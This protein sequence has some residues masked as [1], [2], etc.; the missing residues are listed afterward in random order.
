METRKVQ[1]T[2]DGTYFVTL[3]KATQR[4]VDRGSLLAFENGKDGKLTIGLYATHTL[5]G[6]LSY[7]PHPILDE[8]LKTLRRFPQVMIGD[9][10]QNVA[11]MMK[12][13]LEDLLL[14]LL[15]ELNYDYP[16]VVDLSHGKESA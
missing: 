5:R 16:E 15:S 10:F 3:P 2:S 12:M 8:M 13:F 9:T 1:K 11:M 14:S 7:L 6:Q 4:G